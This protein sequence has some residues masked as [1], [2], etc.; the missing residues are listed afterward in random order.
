MFEICLQKRN[1]IFRERQVLWSRT[2]TGEHFLSKWN[3]NWNVWRQFYCCQLWIYVLV[4]MDL[5]NK[6][7]IMHS[8]TDLKWENHIKLTT[9]WIE[10]AKMWNH[11][12]LI[13]HHRISYLLTI[14]MMAKLSDGSVSM[15][16]RR[17]KRASQVLGEHSFHF[18]TTIQHRF[19]VYSLLLNRL[20]CQLR[21]NANNS[22]PLNG[23]TGPLT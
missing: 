22:T 4:S 7:K 18:R 16:L 8:T 15:E 12:R 6:I 23:Y 13:S 3:P 14:S 2:I 10:G 1:W 11:W 19:Y 20:R 5:L 9:N 17:K 21:H